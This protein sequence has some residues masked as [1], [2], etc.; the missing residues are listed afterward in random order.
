MFVLEAESADEWESVVSG[1][2]VPLRCAGFEPRFTG[3]MEHVQLDERISVSLVT[4]C[5]TSAEH[6]GRLAAEA[7][8][9]VHI[10]LQR[11][12]SGTVV[13]NG[14]VASVRAGSVSIYA[15][16]R[17]YYLDY[18][19]SSQQQ[20]IVQVSRQSLGLPERMMEET[21]SR[22]AVPGGMRGPAARGL[23]SYVSDLPAGVSTDE[24][25][26]VTRD[27]ASSMIRSSFRSGSVTP[28]TSSGLRHIAQQFLRENLATRGLSMDE[29]ASRH[30]VSRRRLYQAFESVGTTPA[31]Y[32]RAERL[33]CASS[34]LVDPA[35]RRMTIENIAYAC[36][37]DDA[38]T[39]TR[40]FRREYGRT[41][42][43]WRSD[44]G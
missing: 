28:R 20:L 27:L 26:A 17:P 7:G 38:T 35:Q 29:V 16:D 41:P 3:R 9:D 6:A 39:F 43:E 25:A 44:V 36:G 42:R 40:A 4:T 19:P 22:L 10:S 30:F 32:L 18:S 14:S 24:T 1:C 31:A 12:S 13:G 34:M 37:F 15:T 5:G 2:F 23:F 21:M 33:R 11:S 8:D